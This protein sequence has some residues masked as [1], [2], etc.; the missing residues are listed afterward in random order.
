[1]DGSLRFKTLV[2]LPGT[3]KNWNLDNSTRDVNELNHRKKSAVDLRGTTGEDR[4]R[5]HMH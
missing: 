4:V 5:R 3:V 1:M 2:E